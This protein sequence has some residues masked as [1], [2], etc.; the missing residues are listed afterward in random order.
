MKER[1]GE[2]KENILSRLTRHGIMS[3]SSV[4]RAAF[5]LNRAQNRNAVAIVEI[6]RT[7][8]PRPTVPWCVSDMSRSEGK[9]R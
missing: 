8:V 4:F 5:C 2:K 6:A 1:A 7:E 3:Q 9:K